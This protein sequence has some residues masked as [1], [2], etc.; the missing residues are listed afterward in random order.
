MVATFTLLTIWF[1]DMMRQLGSKYLH[2]WPLD[3]I[4]RF[5]FVSERDDA[6]MFEESIGKM[7][8]CARLKDF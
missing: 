5:L 4:K 2:Q 7:Y 6:W 3:V 1:A 8:I